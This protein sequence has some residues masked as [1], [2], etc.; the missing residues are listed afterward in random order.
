MNEDRKDVRGTRERAARAV[1]VALP[2]AGVAVVLAA[3]I[4]GGGGWAALWMAVA[5]LLM[6]EA[7]TWRLGSRIFHERRYT[8]LR[9]EIGRFVGL[10]PRLHHAAARVLTEPTPEARQALS[11]AVADM[12]A[13]VDR[14]AEVAG[15]TPEDLPARQATREALAR[16]DG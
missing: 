8:P 2:A 3:V 7:G 5:G 12:H 6:V 1:D 16:I 4:L 9:D 14:M 11:E 15:R 13:S 10:S